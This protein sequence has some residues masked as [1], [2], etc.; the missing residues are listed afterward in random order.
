MYVSRAAGALGVGIGVLLA[1]AVLLAIPQSRDAIAAGVSPEPVATRA[2]IDAQVV[3]AEHAVQRGYAA[4]IGQLD[5]VKQLNLAIGAEQAAAFDRKARDDLY[6]ER[7]DALAV[8]A[9]LLALRGTAADAYVAS[10]ERDLG[11]NSYASGPGVLLAPPLY[12]VVRR[13]DDL[14][15]QT[16]DRAVTELTGSGGPSPSPTPAR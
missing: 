8:I 3:A 13:A 7:Q 2:V 4:S 1:G 16:S 6:A 14:F 15:Q 10:V 12:L 11:Q 9:G 5:K